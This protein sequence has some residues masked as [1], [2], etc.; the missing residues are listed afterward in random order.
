MG[1]PYCYQKR[2][3]KIEN[4]IK[5]AESWEDTIHY[6]ENVH[7]YLPQWQRDILDENNEFF[8]F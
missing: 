4:A 2:F 3:R 1:K 5:Y 6:C 8:N 7:E